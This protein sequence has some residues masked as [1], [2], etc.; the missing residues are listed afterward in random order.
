[1]P[2]GRRL[3]KHRDRRAEKMRMKVFIALAG[4]CLD[5]HEPNE[6]MIEITILYNV[7]SASA[8]K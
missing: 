8:A 2:C 1:M 6:D 5:D 4:C 3:Q 7:T